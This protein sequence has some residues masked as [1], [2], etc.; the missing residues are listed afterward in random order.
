MLKKI[1]SDVFKTFEDEI[2]PPIE[3]HKGLNAVVALSPDSKYVGKSTFLMIIDFVFGG[4]DYIRKLKKF[5]NRVPHHKICFEFEFYGQSFFFYRA[6]DDYQKVIACN[7]NFEPKDHGELTIDQY[8]DF[9]S[10]KY[11][12][13]SEGL[14]FRDAAGR[15]I[16]VDGRGTMNEEKPFRSYGRE[17]D[18]Q[19]IVSMLKLYDRYEK[20]KHQEMISE[21]AEG[22]DTAFKAAI[23]YGFIPCARN[24]LEYNDN[25]EQIA[26]LQKQ[27][28]DL[29]EKSANGLFDQYSML[30][31]KQHQLQSKLTSFQRQK[32]RLQGKLDLIKQTRSD[33]RKSFQ[34]DFDELQYFFPN[35]HTERLEGVE[36]F[37]K[38]MT[39]ILDA[40]LKES[41]E[42]IEAMIEIVTG[43][44]NRL[45]DEF[46]QEMRVPNTQMAL[47]DEYSSLKTNLQKLVDANTAYE[48]EKQLHKNA[49]DEKLALDNL[50]VGEMA[51]IDEML[52]RRMDELNSVIYADGRESPIIEV[53]SPRTYNFNTFSH[54][55]IGSQYRGLILFDL[56][57]LQTSKLPFLIHDSSF[58]SSLD[59]GAVERLLEYY[60]KTDKQIFIAFDKET[61]DT[62]GQVLKRAEILQLSHWNEELY[63]ECWVPPQ[64]FQ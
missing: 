3:F 54:G 20:V 51:D 60:D 26:A 42:D 62:A 6:T 50:I 17:S 48:N 40:D 21:E 58:F 23:K 64:L 7:E 35:V 16:R 55:D 44:I 29:V 63:G 34:R 14:S 52:N 36:S 4:D 57:V 24:S 49:K 8:C 33:N 59:D 22:K 1:Q 41:A 15:F 12:L 10:R 19:S 43:E 9:L 38:T 30:G 39:R 53:E 31:E 25:V 28:E 46:I 13:I 27:A 18:A 32:I 11:G 37:H 45:Q 56:A 61:T 47:L 5:R 2:R